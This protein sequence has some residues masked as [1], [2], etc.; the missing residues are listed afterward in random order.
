MPVFL[1]FFAV[2]VILNGKVTAEICIFGVLISSALFYFMCR[3]MEYSLKKELLLFRLVPLFIRYFGVLVKEIVKAN[4]CVLKI[5]L[6]PELQPEPAFVY[7]DT[8]FQTGLAKVLLANSIT[9]TPGTI[10]VSVEDDRFCVHC[11]DKEL[12]EGME[13]SVFVKLLEEMEEVEARW[14][15]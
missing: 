2:W 4:V 12:A 7:F 13:D 6:S 15:R 10:T 1:L 14:T 9:L 3:Y 8:A 11:L 5:I